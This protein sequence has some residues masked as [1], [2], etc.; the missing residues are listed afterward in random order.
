MRRK[1]RYQVWLSRIQIWSYIGY[2]IFRKTPDKW[3]LTKNISEICVFLILKMVIFLII[4]SLNKLWLCSTNKFKLSCCGV[5][6]V[7][8]CRI[9]AVTRIMET[10]FFLVL[11]LYIFVFSPLIPYIKFYWL[12]FSISFFFFRMHIPHP[13]TGQI[14][15]SC[16]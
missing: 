7:V 15:G 8:S 2:R 1:L 6:S 11:F 4:C 14:G 13:W 9:S 16:I 5:Y 12:I 3:I 10:V